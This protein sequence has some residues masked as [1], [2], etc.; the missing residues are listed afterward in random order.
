MT[1]AELAGVDDERRALAQ[2]RWDPLHGD[3]HTA[4]T[5]LVYSAHAD[6]ILDALDGA[7]LTDDELGC[8]EEWSRYA[9]PFGDWRDDFGEAGADTREDIPAQHAQ[10]GER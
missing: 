4:M 3:R 7:L 1:A 10:N 2:L 9:N 5:V 8:P 6:E